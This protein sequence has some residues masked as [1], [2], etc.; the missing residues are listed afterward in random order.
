MVFLTLLFFYLQYFTYS[1]SSYLLIRQS[2]NS[3]YRKVIGKSL[4]LH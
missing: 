2:T 1:Y 3:K 4:S